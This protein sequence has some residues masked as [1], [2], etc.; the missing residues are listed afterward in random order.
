MLKS[1]LL[2]IS[3]PHLLNA[4]LRHNIPVAALKTR[5]RN[6]FPLLSL[7]PRTKLGTRASKMVCER[8][9]AEFSPR[10][11]SPANW[12]EYA[13]K[14]YDACGNLSRAAK[15]K[16]DYLWLPRMGRFGNNAIQIVH[17]IFLARASGIPVIHHD[18]DWLPKRMVC[19]DGLILRKGR[20]SL[21]S[22]RAGVWA[23]MF[24]YKSAKLLQGMSAQQC[25]DVAQNDV[26]PHM[27]WQNV[28]PQTKA[29]TVY[30][31]SGD[32]TLARPNPFKPYVQPPLSFFTASIKRIMAETGLRK[33]EIIFLD[34][35]NPV[36]DGL[37]FWAERT[38][39]DVIATH[40]CSFEHDT[41]RLLAAEH[42]IVGNSS[43]PSA[44]ALL[45]NNLKSFY[46][47]SHSFKVAAIRATGAKV[48]K[49]TAKEN[50]Y[51]APFTWDNSITQRLKMVEFPEDLIEFEDV[52]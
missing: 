3:R 13:R 15:G 35:S 1:L 12:F 25:A 28:E 2:L 41:V 26:K 39:L 14:R 10:D 29:I 20:P 33:I 4:K 52:V 31:R 17:A 40:Q 11:P 22:F 27:R 9:T 16:I 47:F 21:F 7:D 34:R 45:S 50:T 51:I 18:F 36:L 30:I 24:G 32:V 42:L 43:F 19:A 46:F 8:L 37:E 23:G 44:L 38:G 5:H 6:K 49:A 48:Y